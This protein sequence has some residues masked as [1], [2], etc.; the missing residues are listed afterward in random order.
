M[1]NVKVIYGSSTGNTESAAAVIAGGSERKQS[2]SQMQS[3]RILK[4]GF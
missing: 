3:R 4:P 2:T 1:A